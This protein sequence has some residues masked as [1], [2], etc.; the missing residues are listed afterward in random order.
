MAT[1]KRQAH[2]LLEVPYY[3][4]QLTITAAVG[5]DYGDL[6]TVTAGLLRVEWH[7]R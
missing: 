7:L 5:G 2:L 1:A 4:P 3:L 6:S